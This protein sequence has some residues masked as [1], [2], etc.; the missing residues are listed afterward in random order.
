MKMLNVLMWYGVASLSGRSL[1]PTVRLLSVTWVSFWSNINIFA[2]ILTDKTSIYIVKFIEATWISSVNYVE[3][4][5]SGE[6]KGFDY[7][8][9]NEKFWCQ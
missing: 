3:G 1:S 5:T 6:L 4:G 7:I 9:A 2:L 8:C